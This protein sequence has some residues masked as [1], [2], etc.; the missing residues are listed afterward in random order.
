M[1]GKGSGKV[2]GGTIRVCYI[3]QYMKR[4]VAERDGRKK[5]KR[6]EKREKRKEKREKRKEKREKR[7][8]ARESQRSTC[9][10]T[11]EEHTI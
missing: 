3:L 4:E 9:P 2:G 10:S 1:R 5:E 7:R 8:K 6:R 11:C